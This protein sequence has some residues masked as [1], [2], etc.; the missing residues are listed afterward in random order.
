MVLDSRVV[1]PR[2]PDVVGGVDSD[3]EVVLGVTSGPVVDIIDGVVGSVELPVVDSDGLVPVVLDPV[4]VVCGTLPVVLDS[5]DVVP[6][7]AE[8]VGG[9]DSDFEVVVDDT[10][11]VVSDELVPVVPDPVVVDC[12]LVIAVGVDVAVVELKQN[13]GSHLT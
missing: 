6:W 8:V 4:V 7:V 3:F 9:V 2:V 10:P 11:V 12:G 5:L 13:G 1:L